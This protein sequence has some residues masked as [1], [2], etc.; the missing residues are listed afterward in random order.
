ML[1]FR[2]LIDCLKLIE[3]KIRYALVL[4]F[5]TNIFIS[6]S[7][8]F[9]H[10]KLF[11]MQKSNFKENQELREEFFKVLELMLIYGQI[12]RGCGTSGICYNS[13][14]A[15]AQLVY[16]LP[17]VIP[18]LNIFD[19]YRDSRSLTYLMAPEAECER[20]SFRIDRVLDNIIASNLNTTDLII[21]QPYRNLTEIRCEIPNCHC[22]YS[23]FLR[24][25]S[26]YIKGQVKQDVT[27]NHLKNTKQNNLRSVA[28]E[29]FLANLQDQ[30]KHLVKLKS[31]KKTI[32]PT[33]RC[34]QW[35]ETMRY[36]WR[37]AHM[38]FFVGSWSFGVI[39]TYFGI[40]SSFSLIKSLQFGEKYQEITLSDRLM[41]SNLYLITYL[42]IMMAVNPASV[43]FVNIV[44]IFKQ[45]IFLRDKANRLSYEV[46]K[47]FSS[48]ERLFPSNFIGGKFNDTN[49]DLSFE[50][51]KSAV[52]L[53]IC[54]I[55]FRSEMKACVKVVER[56]LTQ[57]ASF[58]VIVVSIQ[59]PFMKDIKSVQ[60]TGVLLAILLIGLLCLVDTILVLCA[61]VNEYCIKH[62]RKIWSFIAFVERYNLEVFYST[63]P[64][65]TG[66]YQEP[67]YGLNT[68]QIKN[69]STSTDFDFEYH[70]NSSITYH[71][72]LL[73]RKLVMDQ[74]FVQGSFICKLFGT[75]QVD[76]GNILK[77]NYWIL[78]LIIFIMSGTNS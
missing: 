8:V 5:A 77:Y 68:L 52:E 65:K 24:E 26:K 58:I 27:M 1:I 49:R 63:Q 37:I 67:K 57:V 45:L 25:G 47:L 40:I 48:R 69:R 66:V 46:Y 34:P 55:I 17:N 9:L 76:Y 38:V 20:V 23:G 3:D 78:S 54:Y 36:Y 56:A 4:Y 59:T 19:Y 6:I 33:N 11:M 64:L 15:A 74:K 35:A 43:L 53:Y 30:L 7:G 14:I 42:C 2:G 13:I 28:K 75:F 62:S 70:L 72:M 16:C 50:L 61:A 41:G 29:I 32:W 18:Q 39:V 71:T 60:N 73:W 22:G 10:V 51:D 31:K 44:D 21:G 12:F